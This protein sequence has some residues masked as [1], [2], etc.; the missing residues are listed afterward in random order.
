VSAAAQ[1]PDWLVE[2]YRQ[3]DAAQ[4]DD[5]LETYYAEDATLRFGSGPEVHGRAAIREALGHGHA[6]HDMAHT[7]RRVWTVEDTSVCEF[8]VRYTMH[9]D[10]RVIEMPSLAVLRRRASDGLIDDMRVYLDP[11]PL[12]RAA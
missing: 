5:Y 8:T 2:L 3:V 11:T 1:V 4:L 12:G 9:E 6:V 10:G 7:F